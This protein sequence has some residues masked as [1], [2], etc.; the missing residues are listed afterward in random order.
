MKVFVVID[1][2]VLVSAVLKWDSVSGVIVEK[3]VMGKIIPV[4][5]DEI[6]HEYDEV[7]H[8]KKFGFLDEDIQAVIQG[9][10]RSG[11]FLSPAKVEEILPDEKDIIF[12]AVTMKAIEEE[13]ENPA[14]LVTGNLKDFPVKQYVVSPRDFL[15]ILEKLNV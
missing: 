11:V 12:Y 3:A 5:N 13:K 15:T 6:V 8:R 10:K 7:L 14:Y 1:T 2:N 9:L 4:L